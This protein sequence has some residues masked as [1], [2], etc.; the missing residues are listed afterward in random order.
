MR[1]IMVSEEDGGN[2]FVNPI[3]VEAVRKDGIKAHIVMSSGREIY[4]SNYF[5][6]IVKLIEQ[7]LTKPQ[8][9]D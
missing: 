4:T 5:S 6:D 1:M 8:G 3:Q 2:I 9:V 7:E